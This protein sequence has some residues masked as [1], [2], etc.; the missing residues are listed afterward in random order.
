MAAGEDDNNAEQTALTAA[1]STTT[2]G[3]AISNFQQ[4]AG[5]QEQICSLQV[6]LTQAVIPMKKVVGVGG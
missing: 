3:K 1:I 5:R 6:A 2:F 4:L